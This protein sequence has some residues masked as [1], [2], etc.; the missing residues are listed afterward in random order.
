MSHQP[1][2]NSLEFATTNA[3]LKG[4][5]PVGDL[6]RLRDL[7][8]TRDGEIGYRIEG[9][10]DDDGRAA[11]RV[12]VGVRL[13]M[14]CQRCLEPMWVALES[15]NLLVLAASQAEIEAEALEIDAPDRIVANDALPVRDLIE[16]EILLAIPNTPRHER[17]K[18]ALP[19]HRETSSPF[20]GL[21]SMLE[22]MQPEG[23]KK[24]V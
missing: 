22:G 21:R 14:N 15:E 6:P 12:H 5:W 7:I 19:E 17:C 16:D 24:R 11:L 10:R 8:V 9:T 4:L 3:K 20:S 13:Q 2:L 18:R 23:R 1:V